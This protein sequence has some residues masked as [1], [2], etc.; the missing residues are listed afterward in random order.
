MGK[1]DIHFR[2]WFYNL[3]RHFFLENWHKPESFGETD[4]EIYQLPDITRAIN[5]LNEELKIPFSLFLS[6]YK[7]EE[8][9]DKLNLPVGTVKSRIFFAREEFHSRLKA[10]KYP[11]N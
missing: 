4:E 5:E 10:M 11:E 6:G 3:V 1:L 2:D 9:A 7:E 8:I